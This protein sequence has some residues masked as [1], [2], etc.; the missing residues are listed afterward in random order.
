M[1][2]EEENDQLKKIL[3]IFKNQVISES[4][5]DE[6][7]QHLTPTEENE[8]EE[9]FEPTEDGE[10]HHPTPTEQNETEEML[11]VKEDEEKNHPIPFDESEA[12][13]VLESTTLPPGPSKDEEREDVE[14]EVV[15]NNLMHDIKEGFI[16]RRL[17]DG[18]FKVIIL[19]H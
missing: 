2:S 3:N 15:M 18:G 19:S 16:Q 6:T 11:E 17:P 10:E 5:P 9:V 7:E 14:D 8:T 4:L 1:L 12:K 13:E